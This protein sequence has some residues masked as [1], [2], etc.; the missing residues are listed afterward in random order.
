[1]QR[2]RVQHLQQ[3]KLTFRREGR[4]GSKHLLFIFSLS[5]S[6]ASKRSFFH[7]FE[8]RFEIFG[9]FY[10]CSSQ[11]I[12]VL[13][14]QSSFQWEKVVMVAFE[15]R[16]CALEEKKFGSAPLGFDPAT[17][18]GKKSCGSEAGVEPV[19][20]RLEVVCLTRNTYCARHVFSIRSH[21]RNVQW[22]WYLHCTW[23]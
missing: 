7:F 13:E 20:L 19:T 12:N 23:Y 5:C 11:I 1:M 16:S 6:A 10:P 3:E 15:F 14:L 21:S 22:T 17:S 9:V 2:E 8:V 18:R 4:K